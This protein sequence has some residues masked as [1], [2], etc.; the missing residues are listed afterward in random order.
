MIEVPCV[1]AG[2]GNGK[3]WVAILVKKMKPVVF[4]GSLSGSSNTVGCSCAAEE[5]Q[6]RLLK[7]RVCE[8]TTGE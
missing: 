1:Y 6:G 4:S 8:Y 2:T 7:S 5:A 3:E